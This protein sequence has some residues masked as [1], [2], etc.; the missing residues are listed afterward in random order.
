MKISLNY[1]DGV[2]DLEVPDGNLA[3][4]ASPGRLPPLENE[5]AE[6]RK[7]LRSPI[8]MDNLETLVR[9]K[10]KRVLI[11]ADDIT[12]PTPHKKILPILL[13]ELNRAGVADRD[14]NLIIALGTHRP[15]TPD[16]CIRTYGEYVTG[17]IKIIN[18]SW[19]QPDELVALGETPSGIPI[20]V[21]RHYFNSDISIAVGNIIPHIYAGWSGGAKMVQP[22]VCGAATTAKT[23]L[24]AAKHLD[25]VLGNPENIIR[26]EMETIAKETGLSM[27]INTVM[28]SDGSLARVVAGDPVKAH[29]EGVKAAQKI[30]TAPIDKQPDIVVVNA[31]PGNLDFWQ[32][33]K[34][35]TA[36]TLLVKPGGDVILVTPAP[37]GIP[38]SHPQLLEL[39]DLGTRAVWDMLD[40][41]E[42]QDEVAA[43]VH[44]TMGFCREKA[45][46]YIAT[47]DDNRDIVERLGFK[48]TGDLNKTLDECIRSRGE[49]TCSIGVATHGADLAPE[50]K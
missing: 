34:A 30:Y 3:W 39:G 50:Y 19:N 35:L 5:E 36:G 1:D 46:V 44:I 48:F 41:G 24:I 38:S 6:I 27:I 37:E 31:Y 26:K 21:N 13:E 32:S 42:I 43:S 10:G 49:I 33:T 4:V 29:R 8:G 11:L 16:E 45:N 28:N 17:R 25:S 15:M 22:G 20:S 40:R 23:H 12:R 47:G 14:I 7:A 18:H 2:L 9:S